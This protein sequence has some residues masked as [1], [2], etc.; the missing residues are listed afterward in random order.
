MKR[1]L[2]LLTAL[3]LALWSGDVAAA[4]QADN[5]P[6]DADSADARRER[7]MTARRQSLV[8]VQTTTHWGYWSQSASQICL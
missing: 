2:R 4:P 8:R 5:L 3:L 1:T 7:V 6:P